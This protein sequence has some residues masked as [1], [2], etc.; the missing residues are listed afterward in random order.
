MSLLPA[1]TA[2]EGW[3]IFGANLGTRQSLEPCQK[4]ESVARGFAVTTVARGFAITR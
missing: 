2:H 4:G 1:Q 3:T